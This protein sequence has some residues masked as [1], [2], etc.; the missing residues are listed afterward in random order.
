[1]AVQTT[2][3]VP[4]PP[5]F[6]IRTERLTLRPWSIGDVEGTL[7]YYS[8]PDVVRHLLHEVL[9]RDA[10]S[11]RA[12]RYSRENAAPMVAGDSLCLVVEHKGRVVGDLMM[13]FKDG[14]PPSTAEVGW[15]FNPAHADQ[16]FATEAATALIT[17]AFRHYRLHRLFAMLDPRNTDSQ[18][19]CER[20]A[21]TREAHHRRDFWTKGEWSDTYVY[22]MLVEDWA[23]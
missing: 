16:G 21:M 7:P 8:D 19:L 6:P 4:A 3:A 12:G 18:R 9:D 2:V 13:R 15:V 20:L 1:M 22:A 23:P 10:L 5:S 17:L 11:E 14:D